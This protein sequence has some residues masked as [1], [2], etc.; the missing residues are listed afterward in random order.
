MKV[1]VSLALLSKAA[2]AEPQC[3]L[4]KCLTSLAAGSWAGGAIRLLGAP[5][6][7]LKGDGRMRLTLPCRQQQADAQ[8]VQRQPHKLASQVPA[9]YGACGA[10][11]GRE[12]PR[13]QAQHQ[14]DMCR[15]GCSA[16]A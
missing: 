3:G 4:T 10:F 11:R 16:Q 8:A 2:A 13:L 12:V 14:Q 6:A 1:T 15:H 9:V 7:L 5:D